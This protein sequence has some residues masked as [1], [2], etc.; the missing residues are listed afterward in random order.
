MYVLA[1]LMEA[2]VLIGQGVSGTDSARKAL[3]RAQISQ[4]HE[5]PQAMIMFQLLD[6]MC[7][8]LLGATTE[9]DA[10]M[11]TLQE[12]LDV[13]DLW[14][15]WQPNGEFS[16]PVKAGNERSRSEDLKF[17]WLPKGDLWALAWYMNGMVRTHTNGYD[18]K[19]EQC[20]F[21][22]ID[23]V[24]GKASDHSMSASYG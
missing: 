4:M 11:K 10:K 14:R 21:K 9:T 15:T 7:S 16:I 2:S 19:A 6:I 3:H 20:I 8:F 1:N 12:T 13:P 23:I 22:G 18:K 24:N 17:R 5:V